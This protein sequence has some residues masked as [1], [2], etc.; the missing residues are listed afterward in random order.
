MSKHILLNSVNNTIVVKCG[1]SFIFGNFALLY[2]ELPSL[3]F[4]VFSTIH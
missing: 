3:I 1:T 4:H 2:V